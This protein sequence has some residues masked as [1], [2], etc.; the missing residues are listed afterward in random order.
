MVD[1]QYRALVPPF[2]GR[3]HVV[4]LD[5]RRSDGPHAAQV[6][7]VDARR[8]AVE[9]DEDRRLDALL[10]P[11]HDVLDVALRRCRRRVLDVAVQHRHAADV[12]SFS[13]RTWNDHRRLVVLLIVLRNFILITLLILV[14]IIII[15]ISSSSVLLVLLQQLPPF[16]C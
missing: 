4:D 10:A 13:T 16:D 7:R 14:I 12:D 6:R 3:P 2:V 15:S 5:G 1:K 9:G 8:V 11:G